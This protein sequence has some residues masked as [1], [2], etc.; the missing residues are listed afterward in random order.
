MLSEK[1]METINNL[2]SEGLEVTEKGMES[3]K[4]TYPKKIKILNLYCG[5]GGNRK[6]WEG[7]EVTAVELNPEIAKI[8]QDLFPND[9]V[10]I[11]D[12]HE[13][14]LNHY[15][16]FDFIWSSPPC[17]THSR[18]NFLLQ[19]KN[20]YKLRF[21]DMKLYEEIIFLKQW[22]KGDWVVENVRSYYQPLIKPQE[23]QS[24]YFWS[25]FKISDT[26]RVRE[27]VRNDKGQI[28]KVKMEQQGIFVKNFHG[29]TGDKRT[30]LNN[31]IEPELGLHIFI[32]SNLNKESCEVKNES[33]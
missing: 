6:L 2:K 14:L 4:K 10:I 26:Q 8:Y 32:S 12:A 29:Y 31:C 17:P 15:K 24:H 18:M 11:G 23:I 22:F 5:I 27:K 20:G 7:Y 3:L 9:N 25:N 19:N 13:Y 21:P 28:L 30:L 1:A 33:K 16:E